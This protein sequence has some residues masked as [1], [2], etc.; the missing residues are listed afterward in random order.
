VPNAPI[1]VGS[2]PQINATLERTFISVPIHSGYR[3]T[4]AHPRRF[5]QRGGPKCTG[6]SGVLQP[7]GR[8]ARRTLENQQH[9]ASG[10]NLLVAA[11]VVWNAV[12]TWSGAVL[13][14]RAADNEA[15]LVHLTPLKWEH[16]NLTGDYHWRRDGG[17][18]NSPRPPI[19]VGMPIA[20]HPAQIAACKIMHRAPIRYLTAKRS[21]GQG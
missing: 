16:I 7:A 4:L 1:C 19:A 3:I 10:L 17:L 5:K 21:L 6:Q 14:L 15:L 13:A 8:T 2:S 18:R 20:E 12:F 9:R 11:I